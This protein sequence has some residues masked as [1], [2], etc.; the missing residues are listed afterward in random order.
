MTFLVGAL[1]GK[2]GIK[3]PLQCLFFAWLFS[4]G[5]ERLEAAVAGLERLIPQSMEPCLRLLGPPACPARL[6]TALIRLRQS[7][8]S[9][10]A[11]SGA[12]APGWLSMQGFWTLLIGLFIAYFLVG[13][14][15][16]LAQTR[17]ARQRDKS[18]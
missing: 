16:M 2:A 14:I 18:K 5:E 6:H 15:D 8:R 3:A 11:P 7:F 13:V 4:A 10:S 17:Q 1:L 12:A 9:G